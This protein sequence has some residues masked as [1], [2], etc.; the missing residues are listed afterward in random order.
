MEIRIPELSLVVLLGAAGT[1]KSSFADAKFSPAEVISSDK[2]HS[3]ISNDENTTDSKEA[4]DLLHTI[5]GKR[6]QNGLL[7]VIDTNNLKKSD[8]GNVIAAA[9]Q[10]HVSTVAIVFDYNNRGLFSTL[11]QE[12]F[13]RIIHLHSPKEAE[14]LKI[15]RTRLRCNLKHITGPFDIIGDIHGCFDEFIMLAEKLGYSVTEKKG[16]Y[17]AIHP[18]GRKLVFL[19]DLGDRGPKSDHMFQL[20][21]DLVERGEAFAVLGNHDIKLLKY[22]NKKAINLT[23]G[24]DKTVA[25]LNAREGTFSERLKA[26]LHN[27]VSHY[28][29]D[30]GRLVV[31][32]AGLKEEMHGRGSSFV[33]EFALYGETTGERDEFGLPIRNNWAQNYKGKATVV[34]GHVAVPEAVWLNNTID[35][36]TGCVYGN[37]LT[38]LRYP[39]RVLVSVPAKETYYELVR[40]LEQNMPDINEID[41]I[42]NKYTVENSYSAPITINEEN[43][44][45]ALEAMS[46]FALHPKWLIYLPPTMSPPETSSTLGYLEHPHEVFDYFRSV[47]VEKLICEEKHMGSRVIVIVGKDEEA[48]ARRFQI[49]G[50]GCGKCYTRSGR[51]YFTD[52]ALEAE[53]ILHINSVLL[54]A[55]F[56]ERFNTDWAAF[57][58]EMLPWSYKAGRL[59]KE[60]YATVASAAS[61]TLAGAKEAII[62]G[63]KRGLALEELQKKIEKKSTAFEKYTRTYR[64]YSWNVEHIADLRLAP[65]HLLA[66]EGKTYFDKNHLWHIKTLAALATPDNIIRK[67]NYVEV[68]L[69]NAESIQNA[70]NWWEK[71]CA[72][73]SEGM[74]AKPLDFIARGAGHILQPAIK[75]RSKEYLRLVYGAEYSFENNIVRLKDRNVKKKRSLAVKEFILGLEALKRFTNH[76]TLARV[77]EA[78]FGVLALESEEIDPRL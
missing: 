25:A 24:F 53:F 43:I 68:N 33:R 66:T 55:D 74:V 20:V 60:Q 37:K 18:E 45:A 50:E 10:N 44:A 2:C 48:I 1:G 6:L 26:F 70:V 72:G 28:V 17:S 59:L 63:I 62:S 5:V 19:G 35:I 8:R 40:P 38:A 73:G 12:G 14:S 56:W 47:G 67:T 65:F 54:E 51:N 76:E 78:V 77:H 22:L 49:A 69:T 32:H 64:Y 31:A 11:K 41:I 27:L 39:E 15:I 61:Q 46:R 52:S 58:C 4:L 36:D 23:H 75:C 9:R 16:C 7:T 13:K 29:F 71:I 34:Y 30:E 57:D 3:M 21:M 42:A